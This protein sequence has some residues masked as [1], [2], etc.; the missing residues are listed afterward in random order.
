MRFV[1][2]ARS[3]AIVGE[4]PSSGV[5]FTHRRGAPVRLRPTRRGFANT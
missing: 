3:G 4:F 1:A 5:G 2:L